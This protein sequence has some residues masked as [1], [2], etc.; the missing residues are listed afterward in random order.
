MAE[1]TSSS[2]ERV[3]FLPMAGYET[4]KR[5]APFDA[6]GPVL[7][8]RGSCPRGE[9]ASQGGRTE[10]ASTLQWSP[11]ATGS[12]GSGGMRGPVIGLAPP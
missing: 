12:T 5:V 9:T 7:T 3:N 11:V 6:G 10:R 4:G 2:T 1:W 8:M